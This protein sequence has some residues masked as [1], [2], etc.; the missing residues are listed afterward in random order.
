MDEN[1][2]GLQIRKM[3]LQQKRTQQEIADCCGFTKS[4]L[5]KIENR[6]IIPP[7]GTLIKIA[8]ALNTKLSVLVGE[9]QDIDIVHDAREN[10]EQNMMVT[11]KRYHMFAFANEYVKKK[12]QPFLYV[13]KKNELKSHFT[14]HEGEDFYYVIRGEM[15]LRVGTMM[16][17]LKEGDGI[18]FDSSN[19]HETIPI[20]DEVKILNIFTD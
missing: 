4:L 5:S 3:R 9:D 20:S 7:L 16:Y 18:Y 8:T 11:T 6:A 13:V 14:A 12:M 19:E 15:N 10:I 2:I 1:Y 17:H